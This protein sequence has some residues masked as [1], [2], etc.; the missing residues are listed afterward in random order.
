METTPLDSLSLVAGKLIAARYSWMM[1]GSVAGFLYGRIRAT[2][3]MDLVLDCRGLDA[4]ALSSVFE[5]E[6]MLDSEM[7]RDSVE[8]QMMF[9]ALPLQGG[10]K[11]D[12]APLA[13]HPFDR[14]AFAR[15]R[16]VEWHGVTVPTI[17]P[18][19]LVLSKL[20]WAKDSLSDRQ[21]GDVHAIMAMGLVDEDDKY[22]RDWI[23]RLDLSSAL[24]ASRASRYDA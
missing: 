21:L 6:Y 17:S 1:V 9:N 15:R 8:R 23:G 19:D 5:P 11:V 18:D 13:A 24:E 3:D 4:A 14:S 12:I 7:V 2:A 20:R 10:F 16:E 22:F